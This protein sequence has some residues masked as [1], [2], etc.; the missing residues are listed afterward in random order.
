M[1]LTADALTDLC[2]LTKQSTDGRETGGLLLGHDPGLTAT[3]VVRHVGD[4]GP[5]AIR[6]RD[7]FV[8][9]P[10][11]GQRCADTAF[12][13]DGSVWIGDWHT[14]LVDLPTPSPRDLA[15]YRRLLHDPDLSFARFLALI[16]LAGPDND[17]ANPR[18]H[19]WSY[20]GTVLRELP[21]QIA[22]PTT[23]AAEEAT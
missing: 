4:A 9:D 17:W 18:L 8:R 13:L 12:A 3:P 16:V 22:L 2:W 6:E 1:L 19:A 21:V 15:S 20:T 11:H 23:R 7:Q 10:V 14:H 5:R